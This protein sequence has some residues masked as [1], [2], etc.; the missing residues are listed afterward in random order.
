MNLNFGNS[1]FTVALVETDSL[2]SFLAVSLR[3][4]PPVFRMDY[5]KPDCWRAYAEDR[6]RRRQELAEV[7]E[8]VKD[9]APT[10]VILGGDFNSPPDRGT[11]APLRGWI[12]SAS[13]D[14]GY[15]AVNEFPM[16]RIDQIWSRGFRPVLSRAEQT[17]HSDHR[18][19]RVWINR[20]PR[21]D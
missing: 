2:G 14:S 1:N 10:K 19:V 13:D 18:L 17:M 20:Q 16:A 12:Q 9:L 5:W 4:Q 6:R 8:Y 7:A 21:S 11:F 3:L 15:T